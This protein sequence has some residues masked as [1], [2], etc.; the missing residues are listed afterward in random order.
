M[1]RQTAETTFQALTARPAFVELGYVTDSAETEF[2]GGLVAHMR[3][4]SAAVPLEEVNSWKE[5]KLSIVADYGLR[6]GSVDKIFAYA[7]GV[8]IIPIHGILINRFS[9]SWG[10]VTGYNFIQAQLAAALGDEDVKLIV[11][12]VNSPGGMAS[13]CQETSDAIFA[14][15]DVKP[16]V[17]IVDFSCYS[18][19]YYVASAATRVVATPSAGVGSIGV[20]LLRMD[21][22]AALDKAG[23]KVNVMSAGDRKLD[24]HSFVPLSAEARKRL[25]ATVDTC[26]D[27]FVAAVTRNRGL[28]DAAVRG[29]EAACYD[30]PESL[31]L[32]LID[33]IQAPAAALEAAVKYLIDPPDDDTEDVEAMTVSTAATAAETAA[34][35]AATV[36]AQAAQTAATTQAAQTAERA[37]VAGILNHTEAAGKGVLANHLALNTNMTPE[38]AGAVLK[39]AAPEAKEASAAAVNLL[40]AAMAA[41]V[42]PNVSANGGAGEPGLQAAVALDTPEAR[43]AMILAAQYKATGFKAAEVKT[44]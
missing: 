32:A 6:E 8:A 23:V 5:R 4:L 33:A 10:F 11:F 18:A 17:A 14:S 15:R 9:A 29:T 42:Q 30:A 3:R 39:A 20:Y 13:G 22:T 28:D 41:T 16:S 7:D 2:S 38:E 26:Y 43:T 40:E 36:A 27:N 34:A 24:Q 19:A 1:S 25:Q 31:D 12:D 37:R 21:V 35:E 44:N